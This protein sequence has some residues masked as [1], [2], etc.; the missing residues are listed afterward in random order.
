MNLNEIMIY[1]REKIS[2]FLY[3]GNMDSRI[4]KI[5][6]DWSRYMFKGLG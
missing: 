6:E 2:A 5:E 1:T 3:L 4:N